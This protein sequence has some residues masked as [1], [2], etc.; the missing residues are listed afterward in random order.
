MMTD[1]VDERLGGTGV[2]LGSPRDPDRRGAHVSLIHS[3][4]WPLCSALISRRLVVPD[5]RT[6]DT[7]RLGPAP[8]YSRFVD[9]YDSVE[10]IAGVL[11]SGDLGVSAPPRPRVT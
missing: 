1:L 8:I 9:A 10:R 6:P 5:F 3:D 7:V 4:A 2:T 11:E